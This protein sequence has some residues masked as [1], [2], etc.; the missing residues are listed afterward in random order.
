M[1]C[2]TTAVGSGGGRRSWWLMIPALLV[3][4]AVGC[5]KAKELAD[6]AS[7][8]LNREISEF[9]KK[10]EKK[11][12]ATY[13]SPPVQ[14]N[15]VSPTPGVEAG[16]NGQTGVGTTSVPDPVNPADVPPAQLNAAQVIEN[17]LKIRPDLRTDEH[18]AQL[19]ALKEGLERLTEL[20]LAHSR[21]TEA[22]L[23]HVPKLTY[24]TAIDLSF[25]PLTLDGLKHVVEL[26]DLEKLAVADTDMNDEGVELL[27][28]LQKLQVLNL[29][30]TQ[31]TNDAFVHIAKLPVLEALLVSGTMIDGQGFKH[32]RQPLK[33]IAADNTRFGDFGFNHIKGSKF[34]EYLSVRSA[35]VIDRAMPALKGCINLKHLYLDKN[36]LSDLGMSQLAGLK[37]LEYLGLSQNK[38]V[39]DQG[40]A[41]L[42]K[43][44]NLKQLTLSDSGCSQAGG[45]HLK[46]FIP[47]LQVYN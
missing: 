40:L 23:A 18:L 31:I 26:E 15:T 34:L 27:V 17:F 42:T 9:G 38:S 29:N 43:L 24:V 12:N 16:T 5:D 4:V 45:E 37:N 47:G 21:V 7:E 32:L 30:E 6:K 20:N 2:S 8:E 46:T 22:G 41:F 35:F 1:K 13:Q 10:E 36:E 3:A 19:G 25:T 14:P 44:S 28:P 11:D 33:T 39:S